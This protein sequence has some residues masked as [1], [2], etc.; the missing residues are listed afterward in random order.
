M[1]VKACNEDKG[2]A[3]SLLDTIERAEKIAKEIDPAAGQDF[4]TT[5]LEISTSGGETKVE[6]LPNLWKPLKELKEALKASKR[7]VE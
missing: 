5:F 7:A 6:I 4:T 3:M 2:N 1:P